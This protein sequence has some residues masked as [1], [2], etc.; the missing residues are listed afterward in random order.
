LFSGHEF[1]AEK[2][3]VASQAG[4]KFAVLTKPVHPKDLLDHL[5]LNF[6]APACETAVGC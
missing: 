4:H 3:E 2:L 6:K 5:A 1:A